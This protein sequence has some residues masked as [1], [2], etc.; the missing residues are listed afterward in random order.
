MWSNFG[1]NLSFEEEVL[2]W[3]RMVLAAASSWDGGE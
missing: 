1:A 3:T 2:K